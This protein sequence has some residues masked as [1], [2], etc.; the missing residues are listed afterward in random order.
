[1]PKADIFQIHQENINRHAKIH[2]DTNLPPTLHETK[3][4]VATS[5][6]YDNSKGSFFI[7]QLRLQ[8]L[9]IINIVNNT[10]RIDV[11]P[12]D[13]PLMRCFH[14]VNKGIIWVCYDNKYII[15]IERG[16]G[17]KTFSQAF[18]QVINDLQ[19]FTFSGNDLIILHTNGSFSFYSKKNSEFSLVK[20]FNQKSF[21][22]SI[23]GL[24]SDKDEVVL[25]VFIVG[26]I[27]LYVTDQKLNCINFTTSNK[28]TLFVYHNE[29]YSAQFEKCGNMILVIACG[30]STS[31]VIVCLNDKSSDIFNLYGINDPRLVRALNLKEDYMLVIYDGELVKYDPKK[32]F[33]KIFKK[34]LNV[35]GEE[36]EY[37]IEPQ[38][39][40]IYAFYG[41]NIFLKIGF[42]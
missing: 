39:D 4:F 14:P 6:V 28:I 27:V 35:T 1:M 20:E 13:Y 34:P 25:A 11:Y 17:K 30:F 33:R 31:F 40:S 36:I 29:V 38:T 26:E 16:Y 37:F 7:F 41:N 32:S 42:I 23:F 8:N 24:K 12:T 22:S 19:S 2:Y 9:T 21:I 5:S 15:K 10:Q 18:S 3:H